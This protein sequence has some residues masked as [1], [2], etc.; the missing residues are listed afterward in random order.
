MIV[1]EKER[2]ASSGKRGYVEVE[3][4]CYGGKGIV[5]KEKK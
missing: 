2:I 4:G 3:G 5:R 1:D